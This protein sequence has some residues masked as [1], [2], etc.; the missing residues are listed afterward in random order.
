MPPAFHNSLSARYSELRTDSDIAVIDFAIVSNV[1]NDARGPIL[2]E[3]QFL[4]ISAL[5]ADKPHDVRFLG[6]ER[7]I[8]VLRGNSK[9]FG[10]D[11]RVERPFHDQKPVIILL[12]HDRCERLLRNDI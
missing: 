7:L 5:R 8:D 4:A 12:P 6:F 1:A 3:A 10:V 11:H 2:A 9:L